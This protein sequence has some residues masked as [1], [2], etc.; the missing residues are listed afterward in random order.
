[1]PLHNNE[2]KVHF[3]FTLWSGALR[4][5][6][7][8]KDRPCILRNFAKEVISRAHTHLI[9]GREEFLGVPLQLKMLS[10]VF[11]SSAREYVTNH[12]KKYGKGFDILSENYSLAEIYETYVDQ[13]VHLY[14]CQKIGIPEGVDLKLLENS[15]TP[16]MYWLAGQTLNCGSEYQTLVLNWYGKIS[17]FSQK[18]SQ[19]LLG[20]GIVYAGKVGSPPEFLHRTFALFYLAKFITLI[21]TE[22]CWHPE[23]H[24]DILENGDL[25]TVLLLS[26][27]RNEEGSVVQCL[28]LN[29]MIQTS[30]GRFSDMSKKSYPKLSP[31]QK[32]RFLE[33][34][35]FNTIANNRQE[36]LLDYLINAFLMP[37]DSLELLLQRRKFNFSNL[38]SD[39][40]SLNVVLVLLK[41]TLS[42]YKET[43]EEFGDVRFLARCNKISYVYYSM[44][45]GMTSVTGSLLGGCLNVGD[46]A[47][48][49]DIISRYLLHSQN[50]KAF[51]P[52]FTSLIL[53]NGDDPSSLGIL[54]DLR[55]K[56][57][58]SNCTIYK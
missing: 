31:L 47:R 38:Y 57:I 17:K 36:Y 25:L 40:G 22:I 29:G 2:E 30:I 24:K 41:R 34:D 39:N 32:K 11:L 19:D 45:K 3:L 44:N 52:A 15:I 42:V 4:Y 37:L 10:E 50:V 8:G 54:K 7:E 55:E 9:R 14:F 49:E 20:I 21:I 58:K 33:S 6:D 16:Q 23:Q 53:N 35:C 28:F 51:M 18:I 12:G 13:K 56:M 48:G 1:M 26:Q 27:I 46:F 43:N 5:K